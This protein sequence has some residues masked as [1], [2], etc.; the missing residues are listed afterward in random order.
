MLYTVFTCSSFDYINTLEIFLLQPN[1]NTKFNLFLQRMS[2]DFVNVLL[3]ILFFRSVSGMRTKIFS[4]PSNG[5]LLTERT[6]SGE[7]G[8]CKAMVETRN[9]PCEEHTVFKI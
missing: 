2:V 1:L 6:S 5:E 9:Y 8:I 7:D 3:I 4:V